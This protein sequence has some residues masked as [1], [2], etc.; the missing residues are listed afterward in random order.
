MNQKTTIQALTALVIFTIEEKPVAAENTAPDCEEGSLSQ[1][2]LHDDKSYSSF[3]TFGDLIKPTP[4][5]V[6]PR[7]ESSQS[8]AIQASPL[9]AVPENVK[10]SQ[11][12]GPAMPLNSSSS[13]EIKQSN[14]SHD[15][16]PSSS[17]TRGILKQRCKSRFASA[18][19]CA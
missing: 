18:T 6:F 11:Q 4:F 8:I 3:S 5:Q 12:S 16:S 7:T 15:S 1:D 9:N 13:F 10:K 2:L 14:L 19:S 17:Y